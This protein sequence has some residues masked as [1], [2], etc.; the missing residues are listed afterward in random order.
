M[1]RVFVDTNVFLYALGAEHRYRDPCR[2]IVEAIAAR[3]VAAETSVEVVQEF[4]HV[5]GRRGRDPAEALARAE[6][7]VSWCAPV[8]A[9]EPGDLT[10]A[11]ELLRRF[12]TLRPRDAVHAATALN[13]GIE[14]I[15]TADRDLGSVPALERVDPG[16]RAAVAALGA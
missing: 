12:S 5:R 1:R 6:E 14:A 15:L 4:L 11:F 9:F 7:I 13:R 10:R 8:H 16:D 2:A 3:R